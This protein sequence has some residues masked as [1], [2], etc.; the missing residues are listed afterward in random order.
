MAIARKKIITVQPEPN[1]SSGIR[2]EGASSTVNQEQLASG[3]FYPDRTIAP[4]ILQPFCSYT[5]AITGKVVENAMPEVTNGVWYRLTAAN[6]HLGL[7]ASTMINTTQTATDSEGNVYSVFSIITTGGASNYGR[8]TV[9]ENVPAGEIITYV[10]EGTLTADGR[11][12]R[13]YFSSRC[14][15]LTEVP[16]IMF[17]NN[18]TALYDP[19]HGEQYFCINPSLT[20]G[21]PVV[22]KWQSYHEA[23][24]GWVA[25]GS[26]Q[27]DWCIDKVGDGIKIDRKRM[28]DMIMLR[29]IAEVTIDASL[30]TLERVVTHTRMM[31]A[32]EVHIS[33]IGEMPEDVATISPY[34]DIKMGRED[35][36][37]TTELLVEWTNASGQVVGT[38][39]N[40]SIRISDLGASKEL[41][42]RVEDR[43]G[44]VALVDDGYLLTDNGAL[45]ITRSKT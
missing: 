4:L 31:P 27:L 21:Y 44:F 7:C 40:P 3:E 26:T 9:R 5:D 30:V 6:R 24:N 35:V 33:R 11:M 34:A 19:M 10:F 36:T 22:W 12:L 1:V 20:I 38:G 8:L 42:L 43:G 14:D 37:D 13:E 23:E 32:Y 29:C 18:P 17:D 2:V 15:A 41:N 39:I 45:L 28:P 16:D 25:L